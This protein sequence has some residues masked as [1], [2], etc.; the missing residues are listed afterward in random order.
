MDVQVTGIVFATL[1]QQWSSM[2]DGVHDGVGLVV[3]SLEMWID[4]FQLYMRPNKG[5]IKPTSQST[6]W[7][8]QQV[9][10]NHPY[11][12]ISGFVLDNSNSNQ[13]IIDS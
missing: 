10:N 12:T 7:A 4:V 8:Y 6:L 9:A 1:L 2:A 5:K 11:A 13:E 3:G